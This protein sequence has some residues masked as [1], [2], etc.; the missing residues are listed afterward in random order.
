MFI[1]FSVVDLE[2]FVFSFYLFGKMLLFWTP[3]VCFFLMVCRVQ[4]FGPFTPGSWFTS[5]HSSPV[6]VSLSV[7]SCQIL[8]VFL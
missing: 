1:P 6:P 7:F 2:G 8:T 5:N 3:I 4:Y